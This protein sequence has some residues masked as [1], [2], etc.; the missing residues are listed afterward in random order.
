M[1]RVVRVVPSSLYK[2]H[3]TRS[4]DFLG[5]SSSPSESSNLLHRAKGDD[6]I[7][8]VI[9]SG[10]WP[11][12]ESFKD[13]G[14]GPIPSRWKGTCESG[15]QFNSTNCNK[16][17]IGARWFVK[18][19]VADYGREA[20]AKEYL[21]PRDLHGHGTHT[22]STAAGSF[23]ANINYHNN[24]AGTA[25]GGAP[26]ARLAIYKALWTNRGVGSSADILKAID[27]AI[28]DGVDVLSISIGG[29]PPFYPEFTEL[30]DI[31][32][33]SFHAITKG[34]SVVCAAGNSGPSP[35]MVDNVAP[36]IFT[37]A[38]NTID[39]AFLSS[40]TTLRDNTTFMGQSLLESKKDLVAELVSWERCDQLS[41]NEAFINGKVVLC[42][43]KLADYSTI[44][45]AAEVVVR[46]NGTGIIVAGQQ[47][48]N[49]LLA[50]ISSPIPCI[51]VDTIVGSK[52]FFYFLQ[53]SD[54]P[55]V[56]LRAAR[57]IIG[58][59]IAPTIAH[60]SSRGPN[61]VSPPILKPDISAPGSNIL[62]AVSPHYFFN[63][64]GF[65]LMSGTSMATPH[66][67]AIVALLKS[68]HPT[69]SPAA[70]K[71]ALMT[72]ARTEVSPG[73][74]I[75]ADGTPPKVA[76][77]FDYGAGVVDA[78]AAVDPGLI[79]DMGRKDYIDYY[80]CGMGYEDKDISHLTHRKTECPLQRLSL[81]DLNLPAITIPSLVNS[82]IVTRTVTNVG[83]LSCVYKAKIEA[84]FGCKVSVNP[85][86]LVFNSQVK[87]ISFKVMFFTQ[88]Q[89]NYGYS[90]GRLTWSDGVHV[91]KIPLSVRFGFF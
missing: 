24:A 18:A 51:L 21:S 54:H 79:Y 40:I 62:S 27:E 67:S 41:G 60:F 52:L 76:D 71:S 36:W 64:K 57:T 2:V 61:S 63:E 22:A 26:L 89:R 4:W 78:N 81:L 47:V 65:S 12:S 44:S 37:V 38:T 55:V 85:Q 29:S 75:F 42:F 30:S 46:A 3:T 23:V 17:I 10:I 32:F 8:G 91:V 25:R 7:I 50:C 48:D 13:K 77:P 31:A 70:I 84:P 49:N 45:K 68:V 72:T 83:N 20:L 35:Q 34:I 9:D 43:P 19:F 82:T 86:V 73:L 39:R 15:E 59:P 5:L 16:K 56:M 90:F 66:V 69:W 28:H 11:E 6:V 88:V 58:K 80:L 33:G 1:S 74:P 53:N 14:L 87:K